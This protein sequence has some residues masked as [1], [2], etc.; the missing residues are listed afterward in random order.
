M[1]TVSFDEWKKLKLKVGKI[2]SVDDHPNADKLYLLKVDIG[3]KIITLVAGLKPYYK[4][5]DLINKQCIVA[6]LEPAVIRGIKSEGMILA[7]VNKDRSK[8]VIL[9]PEAEIEAGSNVE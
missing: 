5:E 2:V 9:Q 1:G 7:A 6:N 8:V 3:E 4:K